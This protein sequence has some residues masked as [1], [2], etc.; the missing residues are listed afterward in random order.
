VPANGEAAPPFETAEL[1]RFAASLGSDNVKNDIIA[2][3]LMLDWSRRLSTTHQKHKSHS[4][5]PASRRRADVIDRW[6]GLEHL[7][8]VS[9]ILQPARGTD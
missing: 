6:R 4:C 8:V 7:G 5:S 2:K 9:F 1:K 3:W